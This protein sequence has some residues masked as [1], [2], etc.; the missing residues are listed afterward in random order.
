MT[1][2]YL[3]NWRQKFNATA[4]LN[5]RRSCCN[6]LECFSQPYTSTQSWGLQISMSTKRSST[7]VGFGRTSKC[8]TITK[9]F[10]SEKHSSLTLKIY[11]LHR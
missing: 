3:Y 9:V 4:G 1:I 10:T 11:R 8:W 7:R 2:F 5:L 6:K